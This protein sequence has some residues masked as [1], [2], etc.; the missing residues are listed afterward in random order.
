M[1]VSQGKILREIS[2]RMLSVRN[3]LGK[4]NVWLPVKPMFTSDGHSAKVG[5]IS[6]KAK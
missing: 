3:L 1:Y 6:N 4:K 2:I 5:I